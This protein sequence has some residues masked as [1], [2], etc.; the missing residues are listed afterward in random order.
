MIVFYVAFKLLEALLFLSDT[1][2][3]FFYFPALK[4]ENLVW[5]PLVGNH[6]FIP[7]SPLHFL[8]FE[9]IY[10]TLGAAVE[11]FFSAPQERGQFGDSGENGVEKFESWGF[12]LMWVA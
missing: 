5:E 4:L 11:L 12:R 10:G 9:A 6:V 1:F 3:Q 8:L 7:L 2:L